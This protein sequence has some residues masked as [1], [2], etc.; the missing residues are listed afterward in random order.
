MMAA[1]GAMPVK[2]LSN[3]PLSRRENDI[4]ALV[5]EGLT[6][7]EIAQ[8]LFI[9]ERTVDSHLEHV[10]EKLAMNSR[11]QVAGWFVAQSQASA[12]VVTPPQARERY[13]TTA[14]NAIVI[15]SLVIL[16]MAVGLVALWRLAPTNSAPRVTANPSAGLMKSVWS[17]NGTKYPFSYPGGV[18]IGDHGALYVLDRGNGRVQKL[19]SAGAYLTSWG[20]PGAGPGQ[21]IT[22]CANGYC[23]PV[24]SSDFDALIGGPCA[25]LPGSLAVDRAGRVWVLD[26]TGRVQ[27]FDADGGPLF[28][29][30][31]KGSGQGELAGPGFIAFDSREN[32]VISDGRSIQRFTPDG[33]YLG[34]IGNF[35]TAAGQFRLAGS[36]AVDSHD[37]L[38]VAD[39]GGRYSN[40]GG[41]LLKYDSEGRLAWSLS[42]PD[43][44]GPQA[45]ATD[46]NDNL[47]VLENPGQHLKEFDPR[48]RL[49]RSWSMSGFVY[50]FGLALDGNGDVFVTDLPGGD[51]PNDG[52]LS[53]VTPFV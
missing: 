50:P 36:L 9:S 39:F 11:A 12:A 52:R 16:S 44:V 18:A 34:K 27:V 13:G 5:A 23:P 24:C 45:V 25:R 51:I 20:K 2:P 1:P 49:L 33:R 30:G 46:R 28:H 29:W 17:T 41:K 15:A 38:Y 43:V 10:R 37:N 31:K 26:Y 47:W 8:R 21:F 32:V 22:Y 42:S 4:A 35:G 19:D 48:G 53:K 40:P 3:P 14:R 6:N 7:R